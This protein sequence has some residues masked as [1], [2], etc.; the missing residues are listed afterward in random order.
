VRTI[1]LALNNHIKGGRT[2]LCYLL[3]IVA[4][5]FTTLAVTNLDQ[6]VKY[7]D[8]G[9]E[10]AYLSALGYEASPREYRASV[11]VDNSDAKILIV[12]ASGFTEEKI[13]AG[14]LDYAKYW[15]YRINYL[16]PSQGH[17]VVQHGT[18][19][20]VKAVDGLVGLVELRG[21]SQQLKQSFV[22][23]SSISC[24]AEFG[25]LSAD[26]AKFAC[27]FDTTSIWDT[28]NTIASVDTE[29]PNRIFTASAALSATGPNG[30]LDFV[31][32][33]VKFTSGQ[34]AGLNVEIEEVVGN[35]ITL[36]FPTP[37]DIDTSDVFDARPDCGKRWE[38][39]CKQRFD[40]VPW[41]RGEPFARP[42]SEA[43]AQTPGAT[44][45]VFSTLGVA[46]EI[47]IP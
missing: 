39:D 16:T 25:S 46:P 19:G 1:P 43:S 15:V 47:V 17:W 44:F 18:T 4:K 11:D 21:M 3:K 36:R 37:Y 2:T 13:N 12:Q 28:A 31:P 38:E 29:E 35:Q 23:L 10:L 8:G 30:A 20:Q 41:F 32:G 14:L 24:R 5:D 34:N 26:G 42:G 7:D 45:P 40:N 6:N 22:E 33:I 27:N 9:G